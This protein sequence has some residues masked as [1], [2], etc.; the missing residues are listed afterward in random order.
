MSDLQISLLVIGIVVVGAVYLFNWVQERK[1]RRKL[2][3][4]FSVEHDDVLLGTSPLPAV[5]D[6][7]I[8][9]QLQ[10]VGGL[11][12]AP[13][14]SEPVPA[15]VAMSSEEF[16]PVPGLDPA[17][18]FVAQIDAGT[19]IA[20]A[21]VGEMLSRVAACGKPVRA[22]GFNPDTGQWEDLGG[23]R[24]DRYARLCLA[25]Q[26]VD[27][28]GPAGPAQLAAFCDAI[29]G[30]ADKVLAA[31]TLP[32][33][34]EALKLAL[35]LDGFCAEVD[36]AIGI[37]IVAP[38]GATFSGTKIRALAESAGF[39]LEP[40]GVFHF[41]ND[42]RQTLFTLD[43]HEPA[44][45]IPEQVKS[46]STSGIT[47]LL[48]VPRVADGQTV[49]D[50]MVEI[51]MGFADALGGQLVDD[52]RAALTASGIAKIKRQLAALYAQ[53]EESG[54]QAGSERALRLFS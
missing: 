3:Q 37:N 52:N 43:N 39:K 26:L 17:L 6:R 5:A 28:K 47:L 31:I 20:N 40:E 13:V 45:F 38:E 34:D 30:C 19:P 35:E 8:E 29:K 54:I 44:P 16:P 49:L 42:E 22:V 32:D 14:V 48:D 7:R 36:V 12:G 53:M 15:P 4:A 10:P 9:P 23:A 33:S 46:L 27:R 41:R 21:L 51:G 50:R 1:L 2:E 18:D 11:P 25:L 24:G